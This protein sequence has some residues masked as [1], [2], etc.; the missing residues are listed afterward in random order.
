MVGSA[1]AVFAQCPGGNPYTTGTAVAERVSVDDVYTYTTAYT[2]GG[3][4]DVINTTVTQYDQV[5]TTTIGQ[6]FSNTSTNG[7]LAETTRTTN[8]NAF[9]FGTYTV[10]L[11]ASTYDP[12]NGQVAPPF[13]T[14]VTSG[15]IS[16]S[17][18][19]S[20]PTISINPGGSTIWVSPNYGSGYPSSQILTANLG[21][22]PGTPTWSLY[23]S[24]SNPLQLSCT[25]CLTP[26]LTAIENAP[27]LCNN[28]VTIS[29]SI[30]DL[31]A[32]LAVLT[33]GAASQSAA[34]SPTASGASAVDTGVYIKP[35]T[36]PANRQ[37][38]SQGYESMQYWQ[39]NDACGDAM[40]NA[41]AYEA[42]P[43]GFTFDISAANS[44]G[45]SAWPTPSPN[46]WIT[47]SGGGW[48]DTIAETT[49][50]TCCIE[51]QNPVYLLNPPP[52]RPQ[53]PLTSTS[54]YHGQQQILVGLR[55]NEPAYNTI[56]YTGTQTH[57][58]DHGRTQ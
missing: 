32:H 12:C 48:V 45:S 30:G 9:G 1:P 18:I 57:Y 35:S 47:G 56:I 55:S 43:Q 31:S 37:P 17:V 10:T 16:G 20:Q 13:T 26:S 39:I 24:A 36:N 50:F 15:I 29:Y 4:A 46:Y 38:G 2:D 6:P 19:V 42:F 22:A 11:H 53:T 33:N 5:N 14:G 21:G 49:T 8:I 52:L 28:V 41:N 25:E 54:V 7:N 58:L 23:D 40:P 44:G 3:D 51:C 34:S 27:A